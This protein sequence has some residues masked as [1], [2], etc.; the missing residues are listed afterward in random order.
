MLW[1]RTK[2]IVL[3]DGLGSGHNIK[4]YVFINTIR[5]LIIVLK[6][7]LYDKNN[8]ERNKYK[9]PVSNQYTPF[10]SSRFSPS[11]FG[12]SPVKT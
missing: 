10:D 5:L 6:L 2:A 11:D 3:N 12:S 7:D 4:T 9:N 8:L 1:Q